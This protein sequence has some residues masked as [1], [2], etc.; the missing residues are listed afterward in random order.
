MLAMVGTGGRKLPATEPGYVQLQCLDR[1]RLHVLIFST[2][3]QD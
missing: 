2:V 3:G 1:M